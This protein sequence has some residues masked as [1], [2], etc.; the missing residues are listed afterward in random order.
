MGYLSKNPRQRLLRSA[1]TFLSVSV[2]LQ[3]HLTLIR[4]M[5][6]FGQDMRNQF[7]VFAGKDYVQQVMPASGL[8]WEPFPSPSSSI[9]AET[10]SELLQLAHVDSPSST[11]TLFVQL[12]LPVIR[13]IPPQV[14]AV[15]IELGHESAFLGN[16][17]LEL[18]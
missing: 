4:L 13:M 17:G 1:M 15:G 8:G 11:P 7:S 2:A 18:Q 3:L 6:R 14:L 10:A 12:V 16:I 9:Q 5:D